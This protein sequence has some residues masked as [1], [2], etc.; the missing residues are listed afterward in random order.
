M[1]N[2]ILGF[3][4]LFHNS[5]RQL[6]GQMRTQNP[7]MFEAATAAAAQATL[8]G[9]VDPNNPGANN[10]DPSNPDQNPPSF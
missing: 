7:E 2:W 9:N 3:V 6:V 1:T 8:G 5:G 10:P 4:C